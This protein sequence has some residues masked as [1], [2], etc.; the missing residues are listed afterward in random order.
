MLAVGVAAVALGA[1]LTYSGVTGAPFWCNIRKYLSGSNQ[2]CPRQ[3]IPVDQ[4]L[5]I[6]GS[7]GSGGGTFGNLI[8]DAAKPIVTGDP[9]TSIG[10]L[11]ESAL[12]PLGQGGHRLASAAATAF[13]RAESIAGQP[14]LLTD[15]FRTRAQQEAC[16]RAKPTLC[17]TPGKSYH[18]FGLAIDV[19]PPSRSTDAVISAL[20]AAGWTQFNKAKEPWHWSFG[21]TG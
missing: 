18:E 4:Y 12:V 7:G 17:A 21:G 15:S 13:R 11:D 2:D 10:T 14:I 1:G 20:T 6:G 16:K 9:R 5:N 19:A 3:S 8:T